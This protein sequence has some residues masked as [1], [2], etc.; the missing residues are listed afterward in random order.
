MKQK[1]IALVVIVIIVGG[2]FAAARKQKPKPMPPT[3]QQKWAANGVPVQT[4]TITRGDMVQTIEVTGDINALEKV[5]LSAKIQGRV[6]AVTAREGESIS[7]GM[8][9]ITLD[10]QDARSNLQQAQAALETAQIRLSQAYTNAKVTKIQTS[11]AVEQAKSSVESAQARLAVA[12]KP[13]RSQEQLVAENAVESAKA[14][15]DNAESNYKR[16]KKLLDEGAISAQSFDTVKTQ[17][18]VAQAQYKSAQQQ[19]SLIKEGGRSEDVTAA[20]NQVEMAK[21]SLRTAQANQSQNLLRK[22]DIKQAQAAVRQ[23]KAAVDLARQQLS[24]TNIT[25][26]ISGDIASRLT[27]PGQV[28]SP[29]QALADVVNLA[30]VYFKGDLSETAVGTVKKGDSV[31]VKVDALPDTEFSGKVQEI[32]PSGSTLSRNFPIRVGID[33]SDHLLKPGMF[34]RGAITIGVSRD[35]LLVPK[36]AIDLRKGTQSVFTIGSDKKARRH[37]VKVVRE[38]HERVQIQMPTDL[39]AGDV[40]ATHGRQN[41]QEGTKVVVETGR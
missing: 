3:T 33:Q 32:Y 22:E 29:G 14:N 9:V 30:S 40:V 34:A 17:F 27:D 19:L 7:R 1:I 31:V 11:A 28:V 6:S 10:Q 21:E 36:D 12:K 25:S 37:V 8:T 4:D 20:Q 41:L 35:V 24:Y 23:A 18:T 13:A 5:T 38:N 2:L 16:N 15:M 26:P 39:K